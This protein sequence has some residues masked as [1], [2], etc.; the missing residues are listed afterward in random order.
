MNP[1][2]HLQPILLVMNLDGLPFHSINNRI[3][4]FMNNYERFFFKGTVFRK[5]NKRNKKKCIDRQ[6]L[7]ALSMKLISFK[8]LTFLQF[9]KWKIVHTSIN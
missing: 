7:V 8:K 2:A 6:V 5:K 4:Y 3:N 9:W 1:Q